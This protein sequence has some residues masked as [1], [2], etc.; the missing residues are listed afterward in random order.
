MGVT[1]NYGGNYG[2]SLLTPPTLHEGAQN[3]Q[4]PPAPKGN[5]GFF[6]L[7]AGGGLEPPTSAL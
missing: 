3:K 5:R 1:G 2:D 7:V 6:Y 4:K